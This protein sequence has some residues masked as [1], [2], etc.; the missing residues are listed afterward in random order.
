MLPNAPL[1][2]LEQSKHREPLRHRGPSGASCTIQLTH[3]GGKSFWVACTIMSAHILWVPGGAR[4]AR[5]CV[6]S[7]APRASLGPTTTRLLV[8]SFGAVLRVSELSRCLR[9]LCY[10][11]FT[12]KASIPA[13]HTMWRRRRAGLG[14][15]FR[16]TFSL[17]RLAPRGVCSP[18]PACMI[19]FLTAGS[20]PRKCCARWAGVLWTPPA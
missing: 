15:I 5:L 6:R 10:E 18:A 9:F 16:R 7:G 17:Q 2:L 14:V 3:D 4:S 8:L 11:L 12:R 20:Y 13:A 19:M 1:R